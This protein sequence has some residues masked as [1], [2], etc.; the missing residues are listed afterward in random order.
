MYRHRLRI[1]K[2]LAGQH[3]QQLFQKRRKMLLKNT[4]LEEKYETTLLCRSMDCNGLL[5]EVREN[6]LLSTLWKAL[7]APKK[8]TEGQ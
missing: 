3:R 1:Q 8:T 5:A 7:L 2:E 4:V 6:N